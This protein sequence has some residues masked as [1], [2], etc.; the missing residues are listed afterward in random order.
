ML[1]TRETAKIENTIIISTMNLT[2]RLDFASKE[3]I[4]TIL[5]I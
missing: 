3:F 4:R 1:Q 5:F 2:D